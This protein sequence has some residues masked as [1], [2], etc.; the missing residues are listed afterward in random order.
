MAGHRPFSELT[1]RFSQPRKARV[2]AKVADLRAAMALVELRDA[3]Q[4]TQAD[5]SKLMNVK[6]PAVAKFEK[7]GDMHVSNIKRYIEALGGRLEITA[8]IRGRKIEITNFLTQEP[9]S[10]PPSK[11]RSGR[12]AA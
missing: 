1:K 3:L 12:R 2:A 6:Q 8:T 4:I 9:A 10:R 5:L 7:R 11:R